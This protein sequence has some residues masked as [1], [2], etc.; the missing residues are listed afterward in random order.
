MKGDRI[1][2]KEKISRLNSLLEAVRQSPERVNKILIQEGIKKGKIAEIISLARKHRIPFFYLPQ[3]KLTV[4]DPHHQGAI[5]LLAAKEY[6]SMDSILASSEVPFL[7]LL[8]GIADPQNLGSIIR[9]ADG[10]GVDGIVIPERR[11]ALLT[12]AVASVATGALEHVKVARI[13][14][15]ART[16][17]MLR[18]KGVWL[19]GAEAGEEGLWHDFDYTLPV[20][21]V[22][23][24]E[25]T[26][27]RHLV[28]QKC[29]LVLS[30]PLLG[31]MTSLN[32]A[33]AAA[34]FMYE[35]VRQRKRK[36][37]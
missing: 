2:E 4:V 8:D 34:I 13:K 37:R 20:G 28:R 16:M 25:G 11:S 10:A 23:G 17:D 15:M 1:Q 36:C 22:F 5:A 14:N 30:L 21:L 27:L 32:V 18:K 29:D 3:R 26:G 19:V 7:L 33:T 24:S 35:V 9:T 31:E 12:E 6:T